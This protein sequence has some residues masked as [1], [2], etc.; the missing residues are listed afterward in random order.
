MSRCLYG[1]IRNF[2]VVPVLPGELFNGSSGWEGLQTSIFDRPSD[3]DREIKRT[4]AS[5]WRVCSINEN[6]TISPRFAP[7]RGWCRQPVFDVVS[8]ACLWLRQFGCCKCYHSLSK[9]AERGL[10]CQEICLLLSVGDWG[11]DLCECLRVICKSVLNSSSYSSSA[12]SKSLEGV[13]PFF[14]LKCPPKRFSK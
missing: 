3:W 13:V 11:K 5:E 9:S 10:F 4:G 14:F 2:K 7:Q 12:L 6:Y 1:R 8:R